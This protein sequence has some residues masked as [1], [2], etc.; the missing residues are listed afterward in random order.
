MGEG[1]LTRNEGQANRHGL[2]SPAS[3]AFGTAARDRVIMTSI[4]TRFIF[5]ILLLFNRPDTAK[6]RLD[7]PERENEWFPISSD[8]T[9]I[10]ASRLAGEILRLI[11]STKFPKTASKTAKNGYMFPFFTNGEM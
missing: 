7:W 4:G 11:V 8:A 2:V 1:W 10:P 5:M 9:T 6:P 3:V